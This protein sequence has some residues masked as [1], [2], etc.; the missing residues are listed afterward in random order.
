MD[1]NDKFMQIRY[2][3]M[4]TCE[5]EYLSQISSKS[6]QISPPPPP[7]S[8]LSRQSTYLRVLCSSSCPKWP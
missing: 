7:T 3:K 1:V 8:T 5:L 2:G 6:M 4:T